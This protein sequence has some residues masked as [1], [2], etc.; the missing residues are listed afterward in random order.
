MLRASDVDHLPRPVAY[1]VA[2]RDRAK[3][4]GAGH[5]VGNKDAAK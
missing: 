4:I 3:G 2:A 1:A 5:H